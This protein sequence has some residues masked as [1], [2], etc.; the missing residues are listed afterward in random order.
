MTLDT[1][2]ALVAELRNIHEEKSLLRRLE[3]RPDVVQ[4]ELKRWERRESQV[5]DAIAREEALLEDRY[6]GYEPE[7][8]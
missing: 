5:R 6:E 2:R 4:Q 1:M 3:G 7:P 8:D